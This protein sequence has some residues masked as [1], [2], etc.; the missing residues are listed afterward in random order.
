MKY[1]FNVTAYADK[2]IEIE[3]K[4]QDDAYNKMLEMLYDIDMTDA[5]D[6]YDDRTY[7]LMSK[8]EA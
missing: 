4:D 1:R 3:A 6:R 7:R 2:E 8:E 5:I